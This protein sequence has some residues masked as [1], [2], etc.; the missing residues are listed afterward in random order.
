MLLRVSLL[1]LLMS[2]A[3]VSGGCGGAGGDAGDQGGLI[4][5]EVM[6]KNL[7]S[8]RAPDGSTPD[9][10]ELHNPSGRTIGLEGYMLS[11]DPRQPDKY[12]FAGG[13]IEPG[14][15]LLLYATGKKAGSA[16]A[17]YLPFRLSGAGEA[18]TLISPEG[19]VTDQFT[20]APL[21]ADVSYGRAGPDVGRDSDKV[22]F[23]VP[24]P[25]RANGA[26][27]KPTAAAAI[28]PTADTLLINEYCTSN[29]I[30]YDETGD[31]PDWVELYNSGKKPL[32]LS[33]CAL[34]DDPSRLDKWRFPEV[35]LEPNGYL[36]LFMSGK[37]TAKADE[38][39]PPGEGPLHVDFRLS[40]K[41][42]R[43]IVTDR[44]G[45]TMAMAAI[46][47]LPDNVSRGLV[48]DKPDTWGYFPRPT[49]GAV[50]ASKSF[51]TLAEAESPAS[52]EILVSEVC[53]RDG[54][55]AAGAG[56]DWVELYNS[57]DRRIDLA[58]YGLS[59][60]SDKPFRMKL[61]D[62]S[63]APKGTVVIAPKAFS[64]SARGETI[65]LT[66]PSGM[67]EDSFSS[68][69]LRA[70]GS[71]GRQIGAGT[72]GS[73][74]RVFFTEPTRGKANT[75]RA[76][77]GYTAI[78]AI[79]VEGTGG[80]V[81]DGLYITSPVSVSIRAAEPD[82]EIR[83]TLD[84][85]APTKTSAVY[86]G[87]IRIDSSSV[88][89]AVAIRPGYLASDPVSRTLL[90]E[91]PHS[92]PVVSLSG[93]PSGLIGSKGVL[94]NA[95]SY[96]EVPV[97]FEFYEK[98][99]QLG[100]DAAAGVEL[101]G[102]FSRK[103]AQ[104]SLEIKFRSAYGQDEVTYPFFEGNDVT[105]FRRLVLRTSGQDWKWTKVRDAFM[106]RVMQ[107][108][109]AVD[110]MDVRNCV[111]YV[112]GQYWG[113]Y[114]IREKLDQ[115]YVASH[116]GVDPDNVDVIKGEGIRVAGDAKDMK[117]LIAYAKSHDMRD[118][119]A[120]KYVTDRIDED[121]LMDFVIVYS[122]FNNTD[123]GN[124]KWWRVRGEGGQYRWMAF[125][126]DWGLYPSTYKWNCLKGDM[127]NPGGH[128]VRDMFSTA[129]QVR[130]MQNPGFRDKFIRRYAK[131][132]NTTF[133][134]DRMLGIYD[135]SVEIIDAEMPR[136]IER[137]GAPSSTTA[138]NESVAR[139]R[140][141]TSEKRALQI[142]ILQQDFGLTQAQMKELFPNDF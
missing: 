5:S 92:L 139:L 125:D 35:T 75:A 79:T 76:Y 18:L 83:Y 57:T 96:A 17:L 56:G 42:T 130:L 129:L 105:T 74:E 67:V 51:E 118:P 33:G 48:P 45:R 94:R 47:D 85:A 80:A 128:G 49:P 32:D 134:T 34:S 36:L 127:L 142:A 112:N 2:F 98:N 99:G 13:L 91:T 20:V 15:Y 12:V 30:Y 63:I 26:D 133:E 23:G 82:A 19:K 9:W 66:D 97:E 81:V 120:Y 70:G 123:S 40:A 52:K 117:A 87:P 59:D 119:A 124:K 55:S 31:T 141:I 88:V 68:G 3:L 44:D 53:A 64:I 122:F 104:R 43:L 110:T 69:H 86:E 132:L 113:L 103:E 4:I 116:H 140:R 7:G 6:S 16:G 58:G 1:C 46:E 108:Q 29:S 73:L 41:D 90:K 14:G 102:S 114:E 24:T 22:Y 10:I 62:V 65:M 54:A 115:H 111:V 131:H 136:Q 37:T 71:S 61:A 27:G 89:R 60:A 25:G 126:F 72:E 28:V 101:L 135:E 84:G 138:W 39:K 77:R 21:P 109:V 11:E 8:L 121:S 50:N 106:T 78:P 38:A 107:G 95:A 100:I 137:W 93:S